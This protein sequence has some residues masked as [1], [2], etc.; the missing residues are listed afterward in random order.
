MS[1]RL[2]RRKMNSEETEELAQVASIDFDDAMLTR[3]V[4]SLRFD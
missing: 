3:L 1:A 2:A 4:E